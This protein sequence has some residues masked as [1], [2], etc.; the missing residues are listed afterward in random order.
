[1]IRDEACLSFIERV[2]DVD[3]PFT[4]YPLRYFALLKHP[5]HLKFFILPDQQFL[6]LTLRDMLTS[7]LN[8]KTNS[9]YLT[10]DLF[11]NGF[12]YPYLQSHK[13]SQDLLYALHSPL[14]L[15]VTLVSNISLAMFLQEFQ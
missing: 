13:T 2:L 5:L 10:P 1:M 11:P 6:S 4:F 3:D 7:P 9:V 12:N 8:V 14:T 15:K